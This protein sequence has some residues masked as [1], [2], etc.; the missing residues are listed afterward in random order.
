MA[1][2]DAVIYIII[3]IL[4]F[5]AMIPIVIHGPDGRGQLWWRKED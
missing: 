4:G 2:F 5:V 3:G 1:L